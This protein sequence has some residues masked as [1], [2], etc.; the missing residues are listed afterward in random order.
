MYIYIQSKYI[1]RGYCLHYLYLFIYLFIYI[2]CVCARMYTHITFY[3]WPKLGLLQTHTNHFWQEFGPFP[4]S[5]ARSFPIGCGL[6]LWR[7]LLLPQHEAPDKH[8]RSKA[9]KST[10]HKLKKTRIARPGI[11]MNLSSLQ[12]WFRFPRGNRF[13]P[14]PSCV[15]FCIAHVFA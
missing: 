6:S 11:C 7:S 14:L 12:G 9:P 4:A 13:L 1:C 2:V 5:T 3:A 8:L 10:G 15:L